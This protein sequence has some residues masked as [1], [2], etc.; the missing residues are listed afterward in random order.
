MHKSG[1]QWGTLWGFGLMAIALLAMP[2][3][4]TA[5]AARR[6]SSEVNRIL[7]LGDSLSA[8]FML[9]PSE[10]WPMLLVNKLR[11]DGLQFEV[12]NA[13]Q[14]GGTTTGGLARLPP[15]LKKKVDIFVVEL[16]INDAFRGLP[17]EQIGANLQKIIDQV[18]DASPGVQVVIAGMQLPDYGEDGYVR[19]FGQMYLDLASKNHAALIPYLLQGVGGNPAL[20]LSDRI[21]P[22]AAGHKLLAENVWRIL[23]PIARQVAEHRTAAA[24]R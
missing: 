4:Q 24:T 21:H 1:K 23:E 16:G 20:N 8:G 12:T 5:S 15:H 10:A 9:N 6:D 13:S 19:D 7:V 17:V 18:R 2:A 11:D 3:P 14:S 22:N